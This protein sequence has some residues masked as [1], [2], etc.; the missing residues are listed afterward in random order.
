[1]ESPRVEDDKSC[2][3]ISSVVTKGDEKFMEGS[4]GVAV[5]DDTS[6]IE[7]SSTSCRKNSKRKHKGSDSLLDLGPDSPISELSS[8]PESCSVKGIASP[9]P[10]ASQITVVMSKDVTLK[11]RKLDQASGIN[12]DRTRKHAVEGRWN[13]EGSDASKRFVSPSESGPNSRVPSPTSS[14]GDETTTSKTMERRPRIKNQMFD[15][16]GRF[17]DRD[18][19]LNKFII[20]AGITKE[21]YSS[22]KEGFASSNGLH[23][24]A[25]LDRICR[26]LGSN[27]Q[28]TDCPWERM[29]FEV[30]YQNVSGSVTIAERAVKM[31]YLIFMFEETLDEM[32]EL[33]ATADLK[34]TLNHRIKTAKSCSTMVPKAFH[35][36]S[37]HSSKGTIAMMDHA[38]SVVVA[39]HQSMVLRTN[40]TMEH[41]PSPKLV[42][43]APDTISDM[44]GPGS[45][46]HRH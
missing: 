16:L 28:L 25:M 45:Y 4:N 7:V 20:S 35:L 19:S 13:H 39:A 44:H 33:T 46:S 9:R 30:F 31:E 8:T 43:V 32:R 15:I 1:M 29:V 5:V 18:D 2:E 26:W 27:Q 11:K 36:P 10:T 21:E 38:N 37:S 34:E 41:F 24:A 42:G 12:L 6:T 40:P 14:E 22:W 3:I 23:R 17:K